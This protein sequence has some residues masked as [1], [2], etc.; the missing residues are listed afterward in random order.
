MPVVTVTASRSVVFASR[1]SEAM[2][3]GAVTLRLLF[4]AFGAIRGLRRHV[5]VGM[6]ESNIAMTTGARIG[7]MH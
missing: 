3:A 2:D 1:G 7:A 4:V 5:I 6:L